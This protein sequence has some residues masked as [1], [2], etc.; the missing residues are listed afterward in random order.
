MRHPRRLHPFAGVGEDAFLLHRHLQHPP[1]CPV[2]AVHRAGSEAGRLLVVEPVLDLVGRQATDA[3]GAEAGQDVLVDVAA[4][5]LLGQGRQSTGERE[6]LLGP[7]RQGH[8]GAAGV[9]PAAPVHLDLG[10]SEVPL[11]V[12]LA[13]ERL[14]TLTPERVAVDAVVA[15]S[16]LDVPPPWERCGS[17]MGANQGFSGV[18][19][20]HWRSIPVTGETIPDLRV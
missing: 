14:G 2:V 10:L 5:S 20:G 17:R 19:N 8:V 1:Q 12:G 13:G 11:G 18:F 3:V 15:S 4:V 16:F 7:G 6:E 9:E